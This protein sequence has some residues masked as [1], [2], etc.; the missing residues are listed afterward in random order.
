MSP[1]P[2]FAEQRQHLAERAGAVAAEIEAAEAEVGRLTVALELDHDATAGAERDTLAARIAAL[3]AEADGLQ[4][5]GAEVDRR[6]AEH[7][8][9][10]EAA[11]ITGLE[12]RLAAELTA[13]ETATNKL[14]DVHGLMVTAYNTAHD[15]EAAADATA[16]ALGRELAPPWLRRALPTL[17]AATLDV[18][19]SIERYLLEPG[20]RERAEGELRAARTAPAHYTEHHGIRPRK[21][22]AAAR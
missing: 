5:A 19:T 20:W 9:K 11:R 18:E 10:A 2:D 3:R 16:K 1:A 22:A 7:A 12:K 14:A 15:A 4:A 13:L 8:A 6:E 17:T 21:A